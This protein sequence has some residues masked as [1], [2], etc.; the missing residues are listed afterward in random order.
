MKA[1]IVTA[2]NCDG[3]AI[4]FAET[5]S[6][7][8]VEVLHD[9]V[10]CDYEYTDLRAQ[11]CP[12]LDGM[13]DCEPKSNPWLNDE[14]RLILVKDYDWACLEPITEDCDSCVAQKYC[15]YFD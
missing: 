6:K 4:V 13:E 1:W 11:R 2:D 9:D 10:F 15:H 3:S 7:A 12:K 14:I 5:R 8:K